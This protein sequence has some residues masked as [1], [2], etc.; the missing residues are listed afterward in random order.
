MK[1]IMIL[2]EKKLLHET[3]QRKN[4]ID[5]GWSQR[6]N[7]YDLWATEKKLIDWQKESNFSVPRTTQH[8]V[9]LSRN[10]KTKKQ[11]VQL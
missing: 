1:R 6:T 7:H 2:D 9:Y 10:W 5:D 3:M 11:E 4:G 8:L